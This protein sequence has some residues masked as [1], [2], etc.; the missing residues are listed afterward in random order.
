[1]IIAQSEYLIKLSFRLREFP[2]TVLICF[3]SF[4]NQ[5]CQVLHRYNKYPSSTESS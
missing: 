5:L 3:K 2:L 1:M 4:L